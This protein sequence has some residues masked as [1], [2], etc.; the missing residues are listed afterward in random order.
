VIDVTAVGVAGVRPA[1]LPQLAMSAQNTT[2][3][4]I[5]GIV[6]RVGRVGRVGVGMFRRFDS[7]NATNRATLVP[8]QMA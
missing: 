5:V 8:G 7:G 2:A 6:G 3:I 4:G 1:S